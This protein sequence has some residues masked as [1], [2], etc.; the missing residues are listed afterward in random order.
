MPTDI[1]WSQF[2]L[3][4]FELGASPQERALEEK[5]GFPWGDLFPP[6]EKVVNV[7]GMEGSAF[8]AEDRLLEGYDDGYI[9]TSPVGSFEP[10]A[11]GL[12]DLGGNVGEWVSD[13]YTLGGNFGT[14]RGGSW[15]D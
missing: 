10:N 2:A 14:A 4:G 6:D 1:E 12:H 11:L 9:W 8:E 13:S 5:E 15:Q 7:A 3:A